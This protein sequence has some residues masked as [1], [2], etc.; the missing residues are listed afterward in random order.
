MASSDSSGSDWVARICT[1]EHRA[2]AKRLRSAGA[3]GIAATTAAT[4]TGGTR[5][6]VR[7]RVAAETHDA[8]LGDPNIFLWRLPKDS[9][10]ASCVVRHACGILDGVRRRCKNLVVFKIGICS[11]P[12]ARWSLPHSYKSE[13]YDCMYVVYQAA[14]LACAF[15]E[16]ALIDKYSNVSGCRND[17]PGGEGVTD[18]CANGHVYIVFKFLPVPP[19]ADGV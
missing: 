2:T 14:M 6:V 11:N 16:T 4:K 7:R 3:F 12:I 8:A 19:K 13:A 17:A 15:L 18:P 5:T 1:K 10:K 9:A